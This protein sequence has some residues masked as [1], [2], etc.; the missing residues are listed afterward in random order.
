MVDLRRRRRFVTLAVGL[1]LVAGCAPSTPSEL[2]S[3]RFGV[4]HVIDLPT[5]RTVG[6]VSLEAAIAQRR[7]ARAFLDEPLPLSLI[8]QLL[9]AGQGITSP[10]GKRTAPSAGALY[11]LELFVVQPAALLHYVP[12]GH[13]VEQRSDVDRRPDLQAAAFGQD[14]VGTAPAVIVVAGVFERTAR[15]YG[16]QAH[17][18]VN[19]EAGH[20]AENILLEATAEELAAVPIGGFEPRAVERALALPPANEPLYLI[21]V[22]YAA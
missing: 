12:A 16:A 6:P 7:S 17:D 9:W 3:G 11:P 13:R 8:G 19:R 20:A 5:P 4:T 21:P 1:A 2:L 22:G 10:D 18:F 14:S 15:K